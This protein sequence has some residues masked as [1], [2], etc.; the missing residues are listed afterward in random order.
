MCE[1]KNGYVI[2]ILIHTQFF[3]FLSFEYNDCVGLNNVCNDLSAGSLFI[4]IIV[5]NLLKLLHF[6]N[7][8]NIIRKFNPFVISII[9]LSFV[10]NPDII[11]SNI[12]LKS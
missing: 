3:L 8:F 5:S 10:S 2:Y 9:S 1:K 7:I 12:Y 4:F 6:F 11:N